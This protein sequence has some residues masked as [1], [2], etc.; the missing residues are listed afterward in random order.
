VALEFSSLGMTKAT[1]QVRMEPLPDTK[2]GLLDGG[3]PVAVGEKGIDRIE[4]FLAANPGE[5]PRPL[6]KVAS[7]GELSRIMLALKTVLRSADPVPILIFDEVDAGIGGRVASEVGKRVHEIAAG[8][9]VFVI[10][11]LPMI[12]CQADQHFRVVKSIERGRTVTQVSAVTGRERE[13]ELARMLSGNE[14]KPEAL[15]AARALLQEARKGS[16]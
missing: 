9:Q 4:F 3:V 8:R 14:E 16:R 1:L 6:A 15:K 5:E 2:E 11:H 10:T 7:G 12:A 13:E